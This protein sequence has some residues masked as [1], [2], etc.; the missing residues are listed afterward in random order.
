MSSA[1]YNGD[2][3][4]DL[5]SEFTYAHAYYA[6]SYDKGGKTN[7]LE[8]INHAFLDGR[9]IITDANGRNLNFSERESLLAQRDII[10]NNW[11]KVIAESVFKYAG[12]TYKDIAK[13]ETI[14]E[15]NGDTTEA[16]RTY[17]KH[18]GE[19][20]GFALALQVGPDDLGETAE[21]LNRMMGFG[22]VLLNSSQ[23]VGVDSDGN[24]IKDQAQEWSDFKLHMLKIQ[25]LMI[26]EFAIVARSKDQTAD[27]IDLAAK[28]GSS[29]SAEND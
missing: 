16:F 17:A 29:D 11:Q 3:V 1:D 18:W 14:I 8:T 20:K 19:L 25:K 22:P 24:F 21:K 7:Y 13:L 4:V 28:L 15:A 26:D 9:Q 10:R 27:M 2:G 12:S 23:V 6:S 5:Y